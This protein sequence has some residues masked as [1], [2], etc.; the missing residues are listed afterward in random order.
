MD[1]EY[2]TMEARMVLLRQTVFGDGEH[3]PAAN[4]REDLRRAAG[5]PHFDA[6]GPIRSAKAEMQPQIID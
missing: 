2:G 6:F 4:V 5:P 3:L 1:T